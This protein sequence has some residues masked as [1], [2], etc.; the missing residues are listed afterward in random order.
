[1]NHFTTYRAKGKDVGLIF[2]FKY[3]LNGNLKAFEI[4]EGELNE[5]QKEWLFSH[6][7]ADEKLFKDYWIKGESFKKK[8]EIN[9]SPADISFE[10]LWAFYGLKVGKADALKEYKKA[11]TE[12]IIKTFISIPAYKLHLQRTGQNQIQLCRYLIKK[13]YENEYN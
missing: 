13:Y 11:K 4:S 8:F 7:P 6:F 5:K 2:L 9:V 3:D 1:M 10:S 12:S